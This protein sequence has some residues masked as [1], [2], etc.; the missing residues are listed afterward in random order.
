MRHDHLLQ[1][2]RKEIEEKHNVTSKVA[3]GLSK[4]MAKATDMLGG[5]KKQ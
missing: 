3:A 5:T 1:R 2:T 4:G